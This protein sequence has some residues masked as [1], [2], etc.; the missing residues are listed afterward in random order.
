MFAKGDAEGNPRRQTGWR[1]SCMYNWDT[2]EGGPCLLRPSGSNSADSPDPT[3]ETYTCVLGIAEDGR[4]IMDSNTARCRNAWADDDNVIQGAGYQDALAECGATPYSEVDRTDEDEVK[5]RHATG[6]NN[7]FA[8]PW[9]VS[10]YWNFT[11]RQAQLMFSVRLSTH[12][13]D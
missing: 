5:C 9:E 7:Q 11:T 1:A 6:W 4:P 13:D 3:H 12:S 8:F 2:P 10:A